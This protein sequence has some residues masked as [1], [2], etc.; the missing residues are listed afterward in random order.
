[1]KLVLILVSVLAVACSKKTEI[2]SEYPPELTAFDETGGE[3]LPFI[4]GKDLRPVWNL[5]NA[6]PVRTLAEFSLKDQNGQTFQKENLNDKVT[7][8]TFFYSKCP[9]ICP[10]TTKNLQP[11]Q[12]HFIN[13]GRFKIVSFSLTPESDTP[14]VL[15]SYA[16]KNRINRKTWHLLTGDRQSI[17]RLARE[18]FDAD[19]FSRMEDS[20]GK[21]SESDFLHSEIIYLIDQNQNLRGIYSGRRPESV[22]EMIRDAESLIK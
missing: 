8:V 13:E 19:T 14:Q 5:K 6:P 2:A 12:K 15:K 17:Y 21:L 9:G 1:M 4:A 22:A 18:S 3:G 20:R 16:E 10:M 7:A 11:A